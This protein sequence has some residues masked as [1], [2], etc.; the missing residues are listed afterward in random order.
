MVPTPSRFREVSP[1]LRRL[2]GSP[3]GREAEED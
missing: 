3:V 1:E 2:A